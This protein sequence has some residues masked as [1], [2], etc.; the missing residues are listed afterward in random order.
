MGFDW[1]IY[2]NNLFCAS[3]FR[4]LFNDFEWTL[5]QGKTCVVLTL[6][7]SPD[8]RSTDWILD[9]LRDFSAPATFFFATIGKRAKAAIRIATLLS[10]KVVFKI[11]I[12][13]FCMTFK[14]QAKTLAFPVFY[15]FI[16]LFK[17]G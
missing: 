8:S 13:C 3:F 2:Y 15:F 9:I 16:F 4:Y 14:K 6:D 10:Y 5:P 17:I 12:F 7:D 1:E 11:E